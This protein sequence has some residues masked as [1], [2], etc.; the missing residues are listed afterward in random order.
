[1]FAVVPLAKT[2]VHA[3]VLVSVRTACKA[4]LWVE[5]L[6]A[7][8]VPMS[9]ATFAPLVMMNP[10]GAKVMGLSSEAVAVPDV[11]VAVPSVTVMVTVSG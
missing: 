2:C 4:K 8:W 11:A 7:I 1:M 5:D 9:V 3:P 6:P 10:D